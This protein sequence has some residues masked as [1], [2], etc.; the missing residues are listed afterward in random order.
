MLEKRKILGISRAKKWKKATVENCDQWEC[1]DLTQG[2]ATF[3][4]SPIVNK[5]TR[6]SILIPSSQTFLCGQEPFCADHGS[7]EALNLAKRNAEE[8]YHVVGLLER[9]EETRELIEFKAPRL[10]RGMISQDGKKW[11]Q[12]I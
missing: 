3:E 8:K 5:Q 4:Q 9:L 10:M 6:N 12:V 7:R 11:N 1:K 2:N